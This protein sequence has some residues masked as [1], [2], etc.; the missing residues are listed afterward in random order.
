MELTV[1]ASPNAP[2]R[3]RRGPALAL[4]GR[5]S[6][7]PRR[8]AATTAGWFA[9]TP[10]L[11][12]VALLALGL[13]VVVF[14]AH[15]ATLLSYPFDFDQG[16]A[17]DVN[18]GWLLWRGQPIYTSNEVF[19]YYSSNYPPGYALAV[20]GAVG[21]WGPS[22]PAGRAVSLAA[23][24]G[25]AWLLF[26]A[27]RRRAGNVGGLVAV[28][29]LFLSNYL[30]H[31]GALAR[32]NPLTLLLAFGGVLCVS[33]RT[34]GAV[35][36]GSLLLVAAIFTKPTAL[37][38]AAAAIL[39]LLLVD[40]RLGLWCGLLLGVL[41]LIVGLLL[42]DSSA[43]AFSLNVVRGNLNP[44][45][46]GQLEAY[47]LN[48]GL[49]HAAPLAL[50]G[51]SCAR[52]IQTRTV[53]IGH[54]LLLAGLLMA[55]GVAKWGAGES[56]F[57]TAIVATSML[58]GLEAGRL[59]QADGWRPKVVP[60]LLLAQCLVSAHGFV[61]SLVPGLPDRGLQASAL[62]TLPTTEDLRRGYSI[63]SRLQ[64]QSGPA[65]LEE[66]GFALAAGQEIVG[67]PT[68]LRNLHQAGLW[69]GA[70][71]LADLEARR[72]HTVVLVA[73][74]YPEPVLAAIGRYYFLFDSLEIRQTEQKVFV[75]GAN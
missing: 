75:P 17:F 54:T 38:A 34:P 5:A 64:S 24:L 58:A 27:V 47:F 59:V 48:F 6:P 28:G 40:R 12:T 56:Y 62:A 29:T 52:A 31:V 68:H 14:L 19:P 11:W 73:E 35:V 63:V 32:V 70:R 10:L 71:M 23:T 46:A 65:M 18:A 7:R 45:V 22:L 9:L 25:L 51:L 66:S 44:F 33:R 3:S 37:D 20:G 4:R 74:L 13:Q 30:F 53:E 55:L 42:E 2:T 39:W 16:E 69:R 1:P 43:G 21:L 15:S 72:Y 67:N 41:V 60:L 57:L 50:A 8:E 49:L 61:S 26:L 36:L